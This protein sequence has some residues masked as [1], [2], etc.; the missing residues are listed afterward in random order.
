LVLK[1]VY[2]LTTNIAGLDVGGNVE[3]LWAEHNQLACDVAGE[4][5]CL[6]ESLTAQSLDNDV[7][8][9]GMVEAFNGDP[10]HMCMGRSA[11]GRL[12]R[13]MALAG[14]NGLELATLQRIAAL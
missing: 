14:E 10:V 12:Q 9:E 13:A 11:P 7:L 3:Q 8:I 1:N 2:I 4:I 5:V 6:Q